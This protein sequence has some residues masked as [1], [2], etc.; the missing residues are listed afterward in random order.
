MIAQFERFYIRMTKN[1]A[2][3]MTHPGPCDDDVDYY[4]D[5]PPI[6]RQLDKIKPEVL[7]AELKEYGA[8]DADEL[9][10]HDENRRRIVWIAAGNICDEL[11]R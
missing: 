7:L 1:Q 8:W 11:A 9:S 5:H 4:V 10:N 2:I 3:A 6:K